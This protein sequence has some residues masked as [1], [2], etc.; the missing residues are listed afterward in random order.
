MFSLCDSLDIY[1]ED[2]EIQF[3]YDSLVIFV[4]VL[5]QFKSLRRYV[6]QWL[7]AQLLAVYM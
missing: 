6:T 5:L 7:L 3:L 2:Q 1:H 4:F